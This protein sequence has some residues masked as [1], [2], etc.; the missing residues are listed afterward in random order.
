MLNGAAGEKTQRSF[1]GGAPRGLLGRRPD[2]SSLVE[3]GPYN[4]V[5]GSASILR[6][7]RSSGSPFLQQCRPR[8]R[9]GGWVSCCAEP[10]T[11]AVA[12]H[13]S[14]LKRSAARSHEVTTKATRR[15]SAANCTSLARLTATMS[16]T[17]SGRLVWADALS[18][19]TQPSQ[20]R[21]SKPERRVFISVPFAG[22]PA[23][24]S[25]NPVAGQSCQPC[26]CQLRCLMSLGQVARLYGIP[27]QSQALT[28]ASRHF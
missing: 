18:S 4:N 27:R 13:K 26:D 20:S 8:R 28:P 3:L 25:A 15:P 6:P 12:V 11:S 22:Q 16:S 2:N 1:A 10:P 7:A 9:S 14:V 24:R 21:E 19:N 17:V 23:D 5:S